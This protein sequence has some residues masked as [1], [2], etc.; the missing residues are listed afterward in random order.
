MNKIKNANTVAGKEKGGNS[1]E[2]IVLEIINLVPP[3]QQ[4]RSG[5]KF[6]DNYVHQ[7]GSM[8]QKLWNESIGRLLYRRAI[9]EIGKDPGEQAKDKGKIPEEVLMP[10][11]EVV[12]RKP[13]SRHLLQ[14]SVSGGT[15]TNSPL[16]VSTNKSPDRS[17]ATPCNTTS[18]DLGEKKHGVR[19]HIDGLPGED[20]MEKSKEGCELTICKGVSGTETGGTAGTG[21]VTTP[22]SG[23]KTGGTAG[24]GEVTTP[25]STK[26]TGKIPAK[27]SRIVYEE[28]PVVMVTEPVTGTGSEITFRTAEVT[29]LG[30]G[31]E[32]EGTETGGT[33]TEGTETGGTETGGTETGGTAGTGEVTTPAPLK[34]STIEWVTDAEGTTDAEW[35]DETEPTVSGGGNSI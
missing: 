1:R 4:P 7:N 23:T 11:D 26:A 21:E 9:S 3:I 30:S 12:S 8:L 20:L 35:I 34:R 25:V 5:P 24:T 22:V 32:T 13:R 2:E 15:T 28:D 16:G 18:D 14:E 31:T 19:V 17:S 10:S 27:S 6:L 29:T 33:E